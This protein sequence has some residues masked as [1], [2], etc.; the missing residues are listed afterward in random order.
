MRPGYRWGINQR[1]GIIPTFLYD[2]TMI[3]DDPNEIAEYLIVQHGLDGA[4][5]VALESAATAKDNYVLSVWRE[6]KRVLKER[7]DQAT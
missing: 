7:A 6:V 5:T 1:I 4:I 3:H 2:S